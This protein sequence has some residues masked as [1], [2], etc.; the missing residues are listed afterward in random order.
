[1]TIAWET[2]FED[3]WRR[4]REAIQDDYDHLARQHGRRGAGLVWGRCHDLR[5]AAGS[6]R[7]NGS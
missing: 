5:S 6:C 1:M 3:D 7:L 4:S 2:L